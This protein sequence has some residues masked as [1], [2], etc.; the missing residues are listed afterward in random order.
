MWICWETS[1]R[2]LVQ[3]IWDRGGVGHSAIPRKL[4]GSISIR[5]KNGHGAVEARVSIL[6]SPRKTRGSKSGTHASACG[7]YIYIYIHTY[8]YIY[9]E[10][11]FLIRG[12]NVLLAPRC[13]PLISNSWGR[14]SK[15]GGC[16]N[17]PRPP[18]GGCAKR[19][20][21]DVQTASST[22]RKAA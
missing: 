1:L 6:S 21:A 19:L 4:R 7:P 9:T 10:R 22:L 16:A 11:S 12:P 5:T 20:G 8:I 14:L 18:G 3:G 15:W 2:L 17:R 13:T